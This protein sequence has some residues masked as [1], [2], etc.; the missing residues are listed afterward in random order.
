MATTLI[1]R[2]QL[3]V[4]ATGLAEGKKIVSMMDSIES[5]AKR[6]SGA[7][8]GV[9]FQRQL[10]KMGASR[11]HIEQ[12]GRSWATLHDDMNRR[13]LDK[14]LRGAEIAGWKTAT[15]GHFADI[16]TGMKQTEAAART[17]STNFQNALKPAMVAL[18]FYTAAYGGGLMIRGAMTSASDRSRV[19]ADAYFRGLSEDDRKRIGGAAAGAAGKYRVSETD[20]RELLVDASMNMEGGVGGA[21]ATMDAQVKAF[22]LFANSPGSSPEQAI[23]QLRAFNK[24]MDIANVVDPK[25]YTTFLDNFIKSWQVTGRDVDAGDLAQGVKYSRSGSKVFSQ[26]FMSRWLPLIMAQSGGSDAGNQLRAMFDQFVVGRAPKNALAK[27]EEYGLKDKDGKLIGVDEFVQ[28][29]VEWANKYLLSALEKKGIDTSDNTEVARVIGELTNNRVSSSALVDFI[30]SYRSYKRQM[31]NTEK[32]MGLDAADEVDALSLS[33]AFEGMKTSLQ[34]LA[35]AVVPAQAIAAGLNWIADGVNA[36]TQ[37]I[38]TDDPLTKGLLAGGAVAGG[39]FLA[40]KG[41]TG[42]AA[43]VTAGP[44]LMTSAGMLDAAAVRLGAAGGI[45]GVDGPGSKSKGWGA[46]ALGAAGKASPWLAMLMLGGDSANN[47]YTNMSEEQRAAARRKARFL[48]TGQYDNLG[49]HKGEHDRDD[50]AYPGADF[51]M[52]PR[53]NRSVN[54]YS[55][56]ASA[57]PHKGERERD[58]LSYPGADFPMPP[59]KPKVDLGGVVAETEA[60]GEQMQQALSPT[61]TPQVDK[62]Q[63][64]AALA[65]AQQLAKVLQGIMGT[66]SSINAT[67]GSTMRRAHSDFGVAP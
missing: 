45:P 15:L 32:S 49:S 50:L 20:V 37:N 48:A 6:L 11:V 66:A 41:I 59:R 43:L 62:S 18:G 12:L 36:L 35:A 24:A 3:A 22:K 61:G 23:G 27:Q 5:H 25:E 58:D 42:M 65:T 21:L 56:I 52:P 7:S 29:P 4:Q 67:I 1:G 10:E 14:A 63:I 17:F 9:G 16:R 19:D 51:P 53:R 64:E 47:D 57:I 38:A 2:L 30:T 54:S 39:G 55:Q 31:G 40:Y 46:W 60:A 8:W 13:G 44:A 28:N 33:S 34:N 26:D